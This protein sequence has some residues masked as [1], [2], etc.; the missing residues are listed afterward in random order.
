MVR[1]EGKKEENDYIRYKKMEKKEKS[2]Q[3]FIGGEKVNDR[4]KTASY[5]LKL[6]TKMKCFP[7]RHRSSST[8]HCKQRLINPRLT[9]KANPEG[10]GG[11]EGMVYMCIPI[12]RGFLLVQRVM[13]KDSSHE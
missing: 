3:E 1:R 6:L 5:K 10:R 11:Q 8:V 4:M 12:S 13:S 9:T 7:P 2:R